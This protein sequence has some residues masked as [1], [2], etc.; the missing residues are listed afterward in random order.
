MLRS[1][2][3]WILVRSRICGEFPCE[4]RPVI[5]DM[6]VESEVDSRR[7]IVVG[8]CFGK[9]WPLMKTAGV[10]GGSELVEVDRITRPGSTFELSSNYPA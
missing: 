2:R 9:R 1:R 4:V 8:G 7:N 6:L 3:D 5:R 10:D